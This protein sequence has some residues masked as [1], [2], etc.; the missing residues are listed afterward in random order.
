M[1]EKCEKLGH[2]WVTTTAPGWFHCCRAVGVKS[3]RRGMV[4][5][6]VTCGATAY[7][8][9]CLGCRLPQ[10][11]SILLCRQHQGVSALSLPVRSVVPQQSTVS[12]P[13]AQQQS[14]W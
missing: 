14:L 1:Q 2:Q 8:A 5:Q 9:G 6:A 4:L 11:Y 13:A 10:N 12:A 7:C 3:F